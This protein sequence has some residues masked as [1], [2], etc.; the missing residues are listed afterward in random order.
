M[1]P[2]LSKT[3]WVLGDK[4]QLITILLKGMKQ[5]L[6][7]GDEFYENPMPAQSHL[8]DKEMAAVLTY[9]RSHFGNKASA[10]SEAE[11]KK[12]RLGN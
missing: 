5:T 12:V 8:N 10:V 9:V 2:P 1:N 6:E 7:I 4:N 3:K 11:V